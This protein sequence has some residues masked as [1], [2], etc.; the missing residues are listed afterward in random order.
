M[1]T[2]GPVL[3]R[4]GVG[5]ALSIGVCLSPAAAQG[6]FP[7]KPVTNVVGFPAGGGTDLVARGV[8]RAFEKA[9]GQSMVI[10]NV[11]GAGSSIGTTE[12]AGASADGYTVHT[13]SNAF[14]IQPYRLKVTYDVKAFEAV[15]L[16]TASPMFIVTTQNS[17]FKSIEDVVKVAKAEPGKL[18]YGSPGGGTAHQ[19]AMAIVDKA[20]DL[21]LKHV[22]FKGSNE[23]A[24]AMLSGTLDLT[25]AHAQVIEQFNLVA[26]A[27]I[28]LERAKGYEKVPTIKEAT[29][30]AAVSSLW[31]GMV[32]PP[33]TPKSVIDKLDQACKAALADKETIDHFAKQQQPVTYL[34]P[35]EFKK[36]ILEEHE[37]AKSVVEAA[38]LKQN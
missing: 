13:V 25:A 34:G 21:K 11:P 14:V 32:A 28:G 12:V 20:L 33:K 26:I 7:D 30:V 3:R 18:P 2:G 22:P 15:C 36:L 19:I 37:R 16:M 23:V 31:I 27:T 10:K 1:W 8:Q 4:M 29:G 17:R 9:L 24:Q 38:G 5:L 6:T 35:A